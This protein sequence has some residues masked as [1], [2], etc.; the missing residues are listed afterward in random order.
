MELRKSSSQ[1]STERSRK[2]RAEKKSIEQ[3][4]TFNNCPSDKSI[5]ESLL[6]ENPPKRST[7]RQNKPRKNGIKKS[8]AQRSREYRLRKKALEKNAAIKNQTDTDSSITTKSFNEQKCFIKY[9][10]DISDDDLDTSQSLTFKHCLDDQNDSGL[11]YNDDNLHSKIKKEI[12]DESVDNSSKHICCLCDESWFKKDFKYLFEQKN[13]L[14]KNVA[15][16]NTCMAPLNEYKLP[17]MSNIIFI[18]EICLNN[19]D[20]A[21][22]PKLKFVIKFKPKDHVG[23]SINRSHSECDI[24]VDVVTPCIE[25]V[26]TQSKSYSSICNPFGEICIAECAMTNE[27]L[28]IIASIYI[29]PNIKIDDMIYF[30]HRSLLAYSHEAA[31]VLKN[32]K[33][34]LPLILTGNFNIN[35]P[36]QDSTR[37]VDFLCD[38][39]SLFINNE[40]TTTATKPGTIDTLFSR[41]LK[42]IESQI[43][44]SHLNHHKPLSTIELMPVKNIKLEEI[45]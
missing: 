37:L 16:C 2:F 44:I 4:S 32:K 21:S 24:M 23:V 33:D 27:K 3:I 18:S 10:L 7:R 41:Y 6:S 34:K 12:T 35:F 9:E 40:L 20:D 11:S 39:F 1:T 5:L 36:S 19:Y 13:I 15:V 43:Y 31:A 22:I 26:A 45:N 38:K 17:M 30:I 42:N 28:I 14:N 8:S 29:T 25:M